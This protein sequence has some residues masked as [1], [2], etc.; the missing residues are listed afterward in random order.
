MKTITPLKE[1][2][3]LLKNSLPK[4]TPVVMVNLLKFREKALYPQGSTFEP[5]SGRQAYKRYMDTALEK[6][7]EVGARPIWMSKA[8]VGVIAPADE[9]WDQVLLVKYPSVD[10]FMTMLKMPDY[11]E[12]TLHREAALEDSRLIA[13]IEILSDLG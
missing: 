11:L 12:A 6:L 1:N 9:R 5:C 10:A 13:T 3:M 7:N 8:F 4:D 2:L